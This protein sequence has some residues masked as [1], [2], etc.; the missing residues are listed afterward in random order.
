MAKKVLRV[1][2]EVSPNPITV[3]MPMDARILMVRG[4]DSRPGQI[5]SLWFEQNADD[6]PEEIK[7]F[8]FFRTADEIPPEYD[9]IGS[10]I[11]PGLGVHLYQFAGIPA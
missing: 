2:V 4:S 9:Y 11:Y 1:E 7:T 6:S 3:T 10:I 8:R 5:A